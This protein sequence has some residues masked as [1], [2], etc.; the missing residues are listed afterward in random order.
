MAPELVVSEVNPV[1][2]GGGGAV[3]AAGTPLTE[4]QAA[5][6]AATPNIKTLDAVLQSLA[7]IANPDDVVA[8]AGALADSDPEWAAIFRSG[9]IRTEM[10]AYARCDAD[11][12]EQQKRL[13]REVTVSNVCLMLTGVASG[14]VLA[15][16]TVPTTVAAWLGGTDSTR[17]SLTLGIVTLLLGAVAS[18]FAYWA[19]DQNRLTRWMARR[20]EAEAARIAVF[21]EVAA[22][23]AAN[24]P[25]VAMKGLAFVV[26]DLLDAQRRWLKRRAEKH[27]RSSEWTTFWGGIGAA[28][29]FVGG[30][31]AVIG[32]LAQGAAW[33]AIAGV[34][35]AAV[36][37]YA[38][39][40]EA[41]RR[42]RPNADRYDKAQAV[43]D[44]LAGRVDGVAAQIVAGK[45]EALIAFTDAL[46]EQL[47]TEHKQWLEGAA[48][49]E[50]VLTKLDSR[51]NE[52]RGTK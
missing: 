28:L 23:A 7:G 44:G 6:K 40:R 49:A 2:G 26:H 19:R 1:E 13:F 12:V 50:G 29:A 39:N 15:G 20:S 37:A 35:A 14:L 9:A 30:S 34:I 22:Q 52:L 42:D 16:A 31:G 47:M 21:K 5:Q 17:L 11:A 46:T 10:E 4:P 33:L 36:A 45:P 8:A 27:R 41:L 25:A 48:Q 51:L 32:G 43:F 3:S 18:M 24:S 38:T